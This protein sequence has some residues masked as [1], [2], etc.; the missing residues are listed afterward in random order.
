[1]E[2]LE[3]H[4]R[5]TYFQVEGK[6]YQQK[7]GMDMGSCQSPVVSNI[8]MEG[9]EKVV[10][11]TAQYKPALW[12]QYVDDTFVVW[13]RGLDRLQDFL[14]HLSSLRTSIQFTMEIE[15]D[16]IIPFLDVLVKRKG[17]TLTT[18]VYRKPT[19]MGHYLNFESNHL[20]HVKQ[21]T[22]HSLYSTASTICQERQDLLKETDN[23]R[24]D[25]QLIGLLI[26]LSDPGDATLQKKRRKSHFVQYLSPI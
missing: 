9:F 13:P 25:L 24:Y 21:G 26:P 5:I 18:K 16:G 3:V 1:M 2:L 20:P 23:L 17:P 14:N 4:S 12:L 15:S 8:Y 7:D 6:F 11:D 22:V 10:L 19:H